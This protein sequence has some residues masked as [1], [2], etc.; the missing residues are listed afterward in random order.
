MGVSGKTLAP[1]L[2]DQH[3]NKTFHETAVTMVEDADLRGDRIDIATGNHIV[4][5]EIGNRAAEMSCEGGERL[6]ARRRLATFE[7]RDR[8]YGLSREL[9]DIRLRQPCRLAQLANAL[10]KGFA[11]RLI[12]AG[13]LAET[14]GLVYWCKF[15]LKIIDVFF[16]AVKP[17]ECTCS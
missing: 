9:R 11:D 8:L 7:I 17:D 15:P 5:E 1:T 2:R 14:S 12:H 4:P 3:V 6:D 16:R 13:N 10:S